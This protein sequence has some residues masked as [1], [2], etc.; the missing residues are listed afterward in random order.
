[1]TKPSI[2][3]CITICCVTFLSLCQLSAAAQAISSQVV[4]SGGNSVSTK[5]MSLEWSFG[6]MTAIN[7]IT[8][9]GYTISQGLLQPNPVKPTSAPVNTSIASFSLFPNPASNMI[10]MNL[11]SSV[12]FNKAKVLFMD[13]SGKTVKE[14]S[15]M[16]GEA[17]SKMTLDIRDLYPGL[18]TVAVFLEQSSKT[19]NVQ[20][21]LV[22]L[23]KY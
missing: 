21:Q 13:N 18:Y 15:I 1:M 6:E 22:K 12:Q 10:Q 5:A 19:D 20:L 17:I 2:C 4:N 8:T 23:I 16:P 11:R 14:L 7:T 3:F 9:S